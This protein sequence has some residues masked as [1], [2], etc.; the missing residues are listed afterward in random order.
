MLV[1]G[2]V[3]MFSAIRKLLFVGLVCLVAACTVPA[4]NA[5]TAKLPNETIAGAQTVAFCDVQQHPEKFRNSMIRVRA[6]YET[7]FE[8]SVITAPSCS[9]PIPMTWVSFDK[10]WESRTPRR[11]RHP[12]SNSKWGVQMDVVFIGVFKSDGHYGHMDMYPF[13]IEVNKVEAAK[14]FRGFPTDA[15][16]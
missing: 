11:V 12:L 10:Q 6:L 2:F 9:T 1:V 4:Q 7:D 16:Q 14:A 13:S 5:E 15:K 3:D 8:N